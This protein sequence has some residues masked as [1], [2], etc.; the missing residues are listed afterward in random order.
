MRGEYVQVVLLVRPV[1]LLAMTDAELGAAIRPSVAS[2][3]LILQAENIV[4]GTACH[5]TGL[6]PGQG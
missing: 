4:H 6:V 5:P 3:L 2:A 1:V